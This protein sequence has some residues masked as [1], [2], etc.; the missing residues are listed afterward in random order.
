MGIYG[1]LWVLMKRV[2]RYNLQFNSYKKLINKSESKREH[3]IVK[4][5]SY[6]GYR[7]INCKPGSVV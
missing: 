4:L 6:L 1:I 3:L 7:Q 2:N 5:L